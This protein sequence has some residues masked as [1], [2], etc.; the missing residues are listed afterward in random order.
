MDDETTKLK[1]MLTKLVEAADNGEWHDSED[2]EVER[3]DCNLCKVLE[4]ARELL[5]LEK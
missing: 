3:H 1:N 4:E 5:R 2:C